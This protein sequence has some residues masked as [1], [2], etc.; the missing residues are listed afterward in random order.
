MS[1]TVY[2]ALGTNLGDRMVNLAHALVLLTPHATL[3]NWSRVYETPP[4]GYLEQPAFFNMVVEAQTD[5]DPIDLLA[6]LKFLEE[7]LA[8]GNRCATVR[9]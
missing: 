1:H 5:L 9:V 2:L 6:R 8:A 4:W 7:K 3:R